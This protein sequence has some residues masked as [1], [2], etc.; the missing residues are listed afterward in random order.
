VNRT[1]GSDGNDEVS[2]SSGR[3]EKRNVA[4]MEQVEASTHK[5]RGDRAP[6]S[7]RRFSAGF[8]EL[9]GT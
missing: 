4:T 2:K 5:D 9:H 6:G 3:F 7:R 8:V 1:V